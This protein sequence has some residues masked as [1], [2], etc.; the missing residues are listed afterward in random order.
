VVTVNSK[1]EKALYLRTRPGNHRR[2]DIAAVKCTDGPAA[3]KYLPVLLDPEEALAGGATLWPVFDLKPRPPDHPGLLSSR[4]RGWNDPSHVAHLNWYR[5]VRSEGGGFEARYAFR[6]DAE[7][8]VAKHRFPLSQKLPL[9]LKE[10]DNLKKQM[11]EDLALVRKDHAAKKLNPRSAQIGEERYASVLAK[12]NAIIEHLIEI[13]NVR[14]TFRASYD[15][16][17]ML[18]EE[19]TAVDAFLAWHDQRDLPPD[20]QRT[21]SVSH[22][23]MEKLI[24]FVKSASDLSSEYM[25]LDEKEKA[26]MRMQLRAM[27]YEPWLT[28]GD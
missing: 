24:A 22:G 18:R 20:V 2:I 3:K 28:K 10:L 7:E 8:Y 26:A 1:P 15:T 6:P 4:M 13:L 12:H 16:K 27:A 14:E 23:R 19:D 11:S 17:R 5:L 21:N 9:L 25:A